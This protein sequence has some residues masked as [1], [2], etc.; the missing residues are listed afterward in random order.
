MTNI[1]LKKLIYRN[2]LRPQL[3]IKTFYNYRTYPKLTTN[4]NEIF[5]YTLGASYVMVNNIIQK[6]VND[7]VCLW[8]CTTDLFLYL[9]FLVKGIFSKCLGFGIIRIL[10][11]FC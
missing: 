3:Y 5:V 4:I 6:S 8:I 9:L 10:T 11:T 7:L 1:K 2:S